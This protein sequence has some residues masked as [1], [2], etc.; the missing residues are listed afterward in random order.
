MFAADS[1]SRFP[2]RYEPDLDYQTRQTDGIGLALP[3]LL[4]NRL[5]VAS[6]GTVT[7]SLGTSQLCRAAYYQSDVEVVSA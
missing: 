4:L 5:D 3:Q 1:F 6:S 2:D 7:K